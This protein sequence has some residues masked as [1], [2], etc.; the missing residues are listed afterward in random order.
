MSIVFQ[1]TK[2]VWWMPW[3]KVPM[4]DA[5]AAILSRELQ[6][7]DDLEVSEW[8]NPAEVMFGHSVVNP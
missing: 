2:G 5:I 1:A 3:G 8:G 4:K 7:S 6:T